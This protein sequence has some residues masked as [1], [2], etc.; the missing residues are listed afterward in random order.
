MGNSAEVQHDF[1]TPKDHRLWERGTNQS[2]ITW[3]LASPSASFGLM[4]LPNGNMI[5]SENAISIE[6]GFDFRGVQ[7]LALE[8]WVS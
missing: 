8:G 4:A 3:Q 7:H 2:E 1:D 6:D 5:P